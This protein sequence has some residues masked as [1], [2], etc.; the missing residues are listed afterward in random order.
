MRC[1]FATSAVTAVGGAVVFVVA[2]TAVVV[3]AAV[4]S[5]SFFRR[6]NRDVS[7]TSTVVD[8]VAANFFGLAA[9]GALINVRGGDICGA[10]VS[11]VSIVFV[12]F[13]V[14]S[15]D[16]DGVATIIVGFSQ[17]VGTICN[18]LPNFTLFSANGFDNVLNERNSVP[19]VP[20]SFVQAGNMRRP[21]LNELVKMFVLLPPPLLL[22][23]L[24]LAPSGV[25]ILIWNGD[26]NVL[27]TL[28]N[29]RILDGNVATIF[30][31]TSDGNRYD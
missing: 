6:R 21:A 3:V 26:V 23:L 10:F 7:S 18:E 29:C 13:S 11:F 9:N 5:R 4:A 31:R 27:F 22:L 30:V 24:M 14:D 16:V 2:A 25:S 28:S 1:R 12:S 15:V 20:V 8:V 17:M 19:S